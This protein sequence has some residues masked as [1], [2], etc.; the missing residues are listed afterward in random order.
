MDKEKITKYGDGNWWIGI[1]GGKGRWATKEEI[2]TFS[3]P[4]EQNESCEHNWVDATNAVVSGMEC[5]TKCFSIQ[6]TKDMS[7]KECNHD[8][9]LFCKNCSTPFEKQ[10]VSTKPEVSSW[11]VGFEYWSKRGATPEQWKDFIK[12]ELEKARKEAIKF[13]IPLDVHNQV[14]E[15]ARK[16]GAREVIEGIKNGLLCTS[17]GNPKPDNLADW[18]RDCF[19]NN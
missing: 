12:A 16:E 8:K 10:T 11:E 6:A 4:L 19:E 13:H 14:V 7:S 3:T 9:D 15:E 1:P 18:C 5:C 17:C 2:E